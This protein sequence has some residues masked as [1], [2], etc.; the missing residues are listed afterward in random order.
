MFNTMF[1]VNNFTH[2]VQIK[3]KEKILPP[4]MNMFHDGAVDGCLGVLVQCFLLF[5]FENISDKAPVL[6][7]NIT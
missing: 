5:V 4:Y 6:F 1:N 2:V 7:T 3:T